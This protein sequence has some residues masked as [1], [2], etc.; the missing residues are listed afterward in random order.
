MNSKP[1]VSDVKSA[2]VSDVLLDAESSVNLAVHSAVSLD[3]YQSVF[4][5]FSAVFLVV[6]VDLS[7]RSTVEPST[8]QE[9][10]HG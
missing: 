5:V 4:S 3:V 10:Y 6:D 8:K 2:S 7:V 1:V 9:T